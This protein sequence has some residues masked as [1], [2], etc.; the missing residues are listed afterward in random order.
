MGKLLDL[1]P[2][3]QVQDLLPPLEQLAMVEDN[4]IREKAVEGF[5]RL[6]ALVEPEYIETSFLAL[7]KRLSSNEYF[8]PKI[9]ATALFPAIYSNVSDA[10]KR[11]LRKYAFYNCFATLLNRFFSLGCTVVCVRRIPPPW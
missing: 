2:K 10:S 6:V 8:T 3:T 1:V 9:S 11:E 4:A 5:L 7:V